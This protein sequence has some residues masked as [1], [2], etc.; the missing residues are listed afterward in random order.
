M[1]T[2][3]G[4]RRL[5]SEEESQ[6]ESGKPA[7]KKPEMLLPTN[8]LSFKERVESKMSATD[9][10]PELLEQIFGYLDFSTLQKT[11]TLVC[12]N[13]QELVRNNSRFSGHLVLYP[14]LKEISPDTFKKLKDRN[15]YSDP[16]VV[17]DEF[18]R[19]A[20]VSKLT[21][22]SS[23]SASDINSIL[24]AWKALRSLELP[25]LTDFAN[26]DYKLCEN[27]RKVTLCSNFNFPKSLLPY[28]LSVYKISFDPKESRWFTLENAS[29]LI[30]VLD[31]FK[32][33]DFESVDPDL[34]CVEKMRNLETLQLE[35]S[36]NWGNAFYGSPVG[37]D[38]TRLILPLLKKLNQFCSKIHSLVLNLRNFFPGCM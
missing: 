6:T 37:D 2:R 11:V 16:R 22:A 20:M 24:K 31:Y 25:H 29:H 23:A 5:Q 14:P 33:F 38:E 10:L 32:D 13:W 27:L 30:V 17:K 8:E 35:I 1:M 15:N 9:L 4:K 28:W 21:T 12:K 34:A 3:R 36:W 7:P 26:V 19:V 18:K